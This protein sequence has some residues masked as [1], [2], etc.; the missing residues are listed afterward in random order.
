MEIRTAFALI[1]LVGP[2]VCLFGWHLREYGF[3]FAEGNRPGL[4][5]ALASVLLLGAIA[6]VLSPEAGKILSNEFFPIRAFLPILVS[7]LAFA[8]AIFPNAVSEADEPFRSKPQRHIGVLIVILA[9][10]WIILSI[11]LLAVQSG[12]LNHL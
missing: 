4:F 9:W 6:L 1:F 2:A 12:M 8:V 3:S 11:G 10:L 7:G 5:P